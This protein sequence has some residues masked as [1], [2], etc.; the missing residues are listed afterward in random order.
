MRLLHPPQ[1]DALLDSSAEYTRKKQEIE[2]KLASIQD[3]ELRNRVSTEEWSKV[4]KSA[5]IKQEAEHLRASFPSAMLAVLQG[6]RADWFEIGHIDYA[7]TNTLQIN[8]VVASPIE[9]PDGAS[10]PMDVATMDG[11]YSRFREVAKSD[12][13]NRVNAWMNSDSMNI[14]RN[15]PGCNP[16]SNEEAQRETEAA[17]RKDR[18][19]LVG[20]GDLLTHRIDE[21]LL[22]DY[23]SEAILLEVS[24]K[25]LVGNLEWKFPLESQ[26]NMY[27]SA[28]YSVTPDTDSLKDF[29]AVPLHSEGS[30]R[31]DFTFNNTASSS[32]TIDISVEGNDGGDFELQNGCSSGTVYPGDSCKVSVQFSPKT[33]GVHSATMVVEGEGW[34]QKSVTFQGFGTWPWNIYGQ[35]AQIRLMSNQMAGKPGAPQGSIVPKKEAARPEACT[36]ASDS[37][38]VHVKCG[39]DDKSVG[40][41]ISPFYSSTVVAEVACNERLWVVASEDPVFLKVCTDTGVQGYIATSHAK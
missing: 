7:G 20:H 35:P 38:V 17:V 23:E 31:Q 41:Y 6:H 3:P 33:M 32:V 26:S 14:C 8:S 11:V 37:G 1:G 30:M 18:L 39:G 4:D 19:I 24:P 29:G 9:L 21:L 27:S 34:G 25:A 28:Q 15:V 13:E 16:P 22:V 12:I 2:S 10:I 5:Y 40:V 36:M